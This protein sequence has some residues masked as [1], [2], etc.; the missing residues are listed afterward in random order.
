[1]P[2][3][4]HSRDAEEQAFEL[5][6]EVSVCFRIRH[7]LHRYICNMT[8][9][10]QHNTE[11]GQQSSHSF[12]LLHRQLEDS[13]TI[14]RRLSELVHRRNGAS[15]LLVQSERARSCSEAAA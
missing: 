1:M 7:H 9:T 5:M 13:A 12:A 11:S 15:H 4:V 14:P 6:K 8:Q 10:Q 2:L 3:V